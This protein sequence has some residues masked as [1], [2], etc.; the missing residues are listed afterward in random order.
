V[1]Q[2]ANWIEEDAGD[3]LPAS[4]RPHLDKMRRRLERM[5]EMLDAL[6]RFARAGHLDAN[7][8]EVDLAAMVDDM[9]TQLRE[10]PSL[11]FAR[12]RVERSALPTLRTARAPLW[13]VLVNLLSNAARHHD[14][15]TGVIRICAQ[16]DGSWWWF[17]VED[18]GPGIDPRYHQQVFQLFKTL[19]PRDA[20]DTAGMGLGIVRRLAQAVGGE[21]IIE[22]PLADGRGSRFRVRW[23]AVW[24]EVST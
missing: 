5:E 22:S 4:V 2:L 20:R 6:R 11:G 7:A 24:M 21:I 1:R 14:R 9:E 3:A 12:F 13:H 8:Q 18:D 19:Y 10:D 17:H 15:E 23:P 16:Q